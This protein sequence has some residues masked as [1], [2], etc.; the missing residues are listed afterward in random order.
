ME[1]SIFVCAFKIIDCV[2]HMDW[3]HSPPIIV[4]YNL[5]HFA[6]KKIYFEY[7]I[8]FY[9]TILDTIRELEYKN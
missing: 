5:Y 3:R 4:I 8:T 7:E 2:K 6:R 9:E 1:F